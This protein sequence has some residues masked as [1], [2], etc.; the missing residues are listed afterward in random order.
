MQFSN[1]DSGPI[2]IRLSFERVYMGTDPD[3]VEQKLVKFSCLVNIM[4]MYELI[5]IVNYQLNLTYLCPIES[6][7]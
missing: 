1:T 5:A 3:P 6:W 7:K 4:S 2:R